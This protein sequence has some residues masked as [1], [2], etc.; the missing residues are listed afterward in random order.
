MRG[1]T[2]GWGYPGSLEMAQ[3]RADVGPPRELQG[4]SRVH[5][6]GPLP[7]SVRARDPHPSPFG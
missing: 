7:L 2:R 5:D 3:V 6:H 4:P 1:K